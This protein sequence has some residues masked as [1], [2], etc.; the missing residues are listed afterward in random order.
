MYLNILEVSNLYAQRKGRLSETAKSLAVAKKKSSVL[1]FLQSAKTTSHF[2][3]QKLQFLNFHPDR[4]NLL[5]ISSF[6][7]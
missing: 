2:L 6:T 3:T 4:E 1:M 5:F 7:L